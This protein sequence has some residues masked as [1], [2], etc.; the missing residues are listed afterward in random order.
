MNGVPSIAIALVHS[1]HLSVPQRR[2]IWGQREPHSPTINSSDQVGGVFGRR[3]RRRNEGKV[4]CEHLLSVLINLT[5]LPRPRQKKMRREA[6]LIEL[7]GIKFSRLLPKVHQNHRGQLYSTE[8]VMAN[9]WA[10]WKAYYVGSLVRKNTVNL[11]IIWSK[12]E[13]R[14]YSNLHISID[15]E[16]TSVQPV[17]TDDWRSRAPSWCRGRPNYPSSIKRVTSPSWSIK[18]SGIE[19]RNEAI[20]A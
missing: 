6:G 18:L 20:K 5:W 16:K 3:R 14:T 13:V 9:N 10:F 11:N 19:A 17:E 4:R 7:K 2:W 8:I 15:D 12:L 1:R